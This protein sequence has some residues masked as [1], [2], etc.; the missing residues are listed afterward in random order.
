MDALKACSEWLR[1]TAERLD[2][3]RQADAGSDIDLLSNQVASVQEL[4]DDR[5]TGE[6]L[7]CRM[8]EFRQ[9]LCQ[10]VTA[11]S[12]AHLDAEKA[13]MSDWFH[14]L[15]QDVD[16][17][18]DE[19]TARLMASSKYQQGVDE[20]QIWLTKTERDVVELVS[21]VHLRQDSAIRLEQ[22]RALLV[23]LEG[24]RHK[25]VQLDQL[26]KSCGVAEAQQTYDSFS[27]RYKHLTNELKVCPLHIYTCLHTVCAIHILLKNS[28]Q[29]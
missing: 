21:R 22:L 4:V 9:K 11:D 5:R 8:A 16:A 24:N 25:L 20:V 28:N 14:S 27:D 26:G 29:V 17:S 18:L 10:Y 13:K 23:D 7:L 12:F 2:A 3:A 1:N 15:S 6:Q 19:L